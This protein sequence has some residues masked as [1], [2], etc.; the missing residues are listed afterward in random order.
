[1]WTLFSIQF[2]SRSIFPCKLHYRISKRKCRI[3]L[4]ANLC[5]VEAVP[6]E[7]W[8]SSWGHM[9]RSGVIYA[10]CD[11]PR[12]LPLCFKGKPVIVR[13]SRTLTWCAADAS[14]FGTRKPISGAPIQGFSIG[15]TTGTPT[16]TSL[17]FDGLIILST[18][19]IYHTSVGKIC[20]LV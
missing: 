12:S 6:T 3:K 7:L 17:V 4:T 5:S 18:L 10:C 9:M 2:F 1:M 19:A 14:Y 13:F 8:D 15:T 20:H 16:L 11:D